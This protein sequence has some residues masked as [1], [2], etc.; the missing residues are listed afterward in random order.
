MHLVL[1]ILVF[2]ATFLVSTHATPAE[3]QEGNIGEASITASPF[4]RLIP[5]PEPDL[6]GLEKDVAEQLGGARKA[7]ISLVATEISKPALSRAYGELGKLY[8]AYELNE[9]AEAC[10]KNALT[11]EPDEYRWNYYLGYLYKTWGRPKDALV[12]YRKA[13]TLQP[14]N[15]LVSVRLGE[16]YVIIGLPKQAKREFLAAL[17]LRPAAPSILARLGELALT[18]RRYELAVKY[19]SV[20]LHRQSEAN[21]LHYPLAMAYRGLGRTEEARLHL[22]QSGP[23][24][25]QPPD[26]LAAELRDLLRGERAFL[27]RGKLAYAAGR[28]AEAT[29][30]FRQALVADEKSVRAR[31][32]LGSALAGLGKTQES[33]EQYRAAIS[34]A[35]GNLTARYNLGFLL[36]KTGAFR[37]AAGH[38]KMV[39]EERPEDAEVHEVLAT[40]LEGDGQVE[41][42]LEYYRRTVRLDPSAANAWLGG[43]NLLAREGRYSKALSVLEQAHKR[44]PANGLIAHALARILAGVPGEELRDGSRA[45]PLALKVFKA[46]PSGFHAET[47]AMAY[48]ETDDCEQAAKW[49]QRA[50]EAENGNKAGNRGAQ[51]R[52]MLS[53]YREQQPCRHPQ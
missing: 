17:Y 22:A 16:T 25:I 47:V 2:F 33:I 28:Y 49:Q 27:L 10:Y 31:I 6:S 43:S 7:L 52:E 46:Q 39:V 38:L 36:N 4:E 53:Y 40:A 51:L 37:E 42:A 15:P 30:A 9:P 41:D 21:R 3:T 19:L 20:A 26:P 5:V 24:G 45:L 18:E 11:L 29:E 44:L 48:A 50:V 8:Q 34:L 35:P 13:K 14:D 23:V 12:Y 32:N 1:L